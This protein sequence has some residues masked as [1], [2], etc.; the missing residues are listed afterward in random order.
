MRVEAKRSGRISKHVRREL[1]R[2]QVG[3]FHPERIHRQ[4]RNVVLR[5]IL[6]DLC[7]KS[8][9]KGVLA[10]TSSCRSS[11]LVYNRLRRHRRESKKE[12]GKYGSTSC[13]YDV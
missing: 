1:Y 7:K 5:P 9:D 8:I 11:Y 4:R 3:V 13:S 10:P 12:Q 2:S 6:I